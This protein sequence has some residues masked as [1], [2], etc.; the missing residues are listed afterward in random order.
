[1]LELNHG[2]RVVDANAWLPGGEGTAAEEGAESLEREMHQAGV[3]RSVVYP[4]PH[5][6]TVADGDYL[7]AN[8]AIARGTVERPL[9]AFARLNGPRDPGESA[10]AQL[11]NLAARRDDN[12]TS[13]EEV[14]QYAYD[15][16]F[17]GFMLDPVRD[18]LPDGETLDAL[19]TVDLPVL[20]H[21]GA[22]FPPESA[23]P[24]LERGFPVVLAHFGGFPLDEDRMG[25]TVELLGTHDD[26]YLDT[27]AV[28]YRSVLERA[29]REHPDRV[30]FGS[31]APTVHPNVGVMEILTLDVPED[32]M[33]RVFSKNA[34]RV[35]DAL[36]PEG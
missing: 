23:G 8:N 25:R 1:M 9:V 16:R 15:D 20:V 2:F 30:L 10:T 35:V 6:E 31:G 24:L 14:E 33:R 26:L 34:A 29:I 4:G 17:H 32:S 18:G 13:P 19:G 36:G 21:A 27:S 7:R 5:G 3:V 22:G 12:H 28:R 11:R